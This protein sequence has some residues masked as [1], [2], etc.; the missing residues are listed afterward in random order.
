VAYW[1]WSQLALEGVPMTGKWILAAALGAS[2][3]AIGA[4]AQGPQGVGAAEAA[5]SDSGIHISNPIKWVKKDPNAET[6]SLDAKADQSTKLSA[7]LQM[8]NVLPAN[9]NVK[10]ACSTIKELSDCVAALHA[11]RN[12]GVDFDCL[13]SLVSGVQ[14]K[15]DQPGC[16]TGTDGKPAS[17]AKAIHSLKPDADAKGEAKKADAQARD[18]LKELG[19]GI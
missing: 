5:R 10:D 7:R 14:V 19:T 2:L 18:D 15:L 6:A 16:K 12:L 3:S 4:A 9:G 8:E 1:G 11:G 17:L 13:K